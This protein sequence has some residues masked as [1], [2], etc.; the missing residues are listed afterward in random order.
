[1]RRWSVASR[2]LRSLI[3]AMWVSLATISTA[4]AQPSPT[5]AVTLP[6]GTWTVQGREIPG[7]QCGRWLVRL[8]NTQG[9][10]T[11]VVSLARASVPIQDL[12]VMPDGS[13][14]GTTRAG[15]VGTTRARAYKVSG[16]F[17]GDT[18]HLTLATNFC[19]DRHGVATRQA[20]RQ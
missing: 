12:T 20:T 2:P 13:F 9:R 7:T 14:F 17:L 8:T 11:G 10:L 19:P 16:K 6:N 18:V 4:R 5:A 3:I 15:V 1:M